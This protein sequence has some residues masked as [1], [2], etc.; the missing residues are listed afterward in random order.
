MSAPKDDFGFIA[1]DDLEKEKDEF[2]FTPWFP[3]EQ[4]DKKESFV[5]DILEQIISK[6]ASGVVGG[7][8]NILESVGLQPQDQIQT[9]AQEARSSAEFEILEKMRRG[10]RPSFSELLALSEDEYPDISRLPTSKEA[11]KGIETFTGIGEGK[12]PAGRIVG[13]GAEFLGEGLSIPGGGLK[14]LATLAG[15]GTAGQAT[16]ELG[17]PESLASGVEIVGSIVP[18]VVQGKVIPRGSLANQVVDAGRKIGLSEKQIAPLVQ[19]EKKVATLSKIARKGTKTK[20]LF[21]SI[22]EKL[23]DSYSVIKSNPEAKIKIPNSDQINLRKQFGNIRNEMSKTLAPSPEKEAALKYIET[24][25]ENL[26]NVD[27]T[28]EYM[29]NFWQDINKSVKWN[30]ISGGKKALAKLKEP[31]SEIFKKVNPNLAQDFEMTNLL[32][33]KYAQVS[34]KLRPDFIESLINKGEILAIPAAAFAM[35][36]GNLGIV[37]G[38]AG[39]HALRVLGREMLINPYFQNL[40]S[41]LVR[42]FN[43]SS[44]KGITESVNEARKYLEKKY[45]DEDWGFISTID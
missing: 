2:G 28:P 20:E 9:P 18:T 40:S 3:A 8:G 12:T 15:A 10:E 5:K 45:P 19:G 39:E 43:K 16:R 14:S 7:Y 37:T 34:K 26:R 35:I 42:N 6:A 23:G 11:K 31:V 4:T 30:S 22:K 41:K 29:V 44:V 38:L 33:Q 24:A 36:Q 13:R 32:Y 27:V 1:F 25:L 21:S 17:G